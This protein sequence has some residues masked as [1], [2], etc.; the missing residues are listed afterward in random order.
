MGPANSTSN[1]TLTTPVKSSKE[2]AACIDAVSQNRYY[3]ETPDAD[4]V[5]SAT[6]GEG[7]GTTTVSWKTKKPLDGFPPRES[8]S[9][10]STRVFR[11]MGIRRFSPRHMLILRGPMWP[12][13]PSGA[14][15][16]DEEIGKQGYKSTAGGSHMALLCNS[17]KLRLP[18]DMRSL[19]LPLL[20]RPSYDKGMNRTM[21]VII[22]TIPPIATDEGTDSP[23]RSLRESGQIYPRIATVSQTDGPSLGHTP[24]LGLMIG[25]ILGGGITR[26]SNN[27]IYSHSTLAHT[28]PESGE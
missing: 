8:R 22:P 3:H 17:S 19:P 15:E 26:T 16:E 6:P 28:K 24:A 23:L 21:V 12:L 11:I 4:F 13:P 20:G 1:S 27:S 2:Y 7:I 10:S 14:S 18:P 5:S 9:T 25:G